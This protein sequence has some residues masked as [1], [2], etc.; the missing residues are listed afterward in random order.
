VALAWLLRRSSVALPIP[1]TSSAAHVE[2]NIAAAG[3]SL[4]DD[5]FKKLSEVNPPPAS[6]R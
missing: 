4:A 2:E 1:G 6:L 3:I 5:L